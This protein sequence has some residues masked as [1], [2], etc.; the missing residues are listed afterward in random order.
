[1]YSATFVAM[2]LSSVALQVA[3]KIGSCNGAFRQRTLNISGCE[4]NSGGKTQENMREFLQ[5]KSVQ[6]SDTQNNI[7]PHV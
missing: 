2:L 1:M 7:C 5:F 3:G 4:T 6:Y